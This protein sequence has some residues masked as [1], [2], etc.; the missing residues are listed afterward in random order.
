MIKRLLCFL[1]LLLAACAPSEQQ[2]GAAGTGA[3][4][5]MKFIS[6]AFQPGGAIPKLYTC[7]GEDRSPALVW[8]APPEGTKSLVLVMDDP[9]APGKTWVHW[10]VYNLPPDSRGLDEG[11]SAA[12]QPSTLPEGAQVGKNSWGREEYGGPC[13]P[14]GTHHY[15]FRLYAVDTILEDAALDKAALLKAIDGHVLAQGEHMGT[16]AKE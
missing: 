8:A 11:A 14:T 3:P 16:Y 6:P 12:K 1:L 9:D 10:L 13:P 5:G 4:A 2:P 15:S 7:Q